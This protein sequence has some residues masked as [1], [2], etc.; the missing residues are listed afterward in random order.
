MDRMPRSICEQRP[1]EIVA[2]CRKLYQR[3]SFQE[4]TLGEISKETSISRPSI[5][6]YFH[7]KEEIFLA[8]LQE[9]Y[10]LWTA[11]LTQSFAKHPALTAQEYA[12][13]VGQSLEKRITLLKIQCM[14]LYEIEEHSRL[15]CLVEFKKSYQ[16]TLSTVEKSL[17]KFFPAMSPKDR[18]IFLYLFFPFL[19]GLYP[20]VY[21]TTQQQ[22]AMERAHIQLSPQKVSDLAALCLLKLLPN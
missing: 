10:E 8:L 7:S 19:Y 20:Y 9:E 13:L 2:A 3:L 5:Y 12:A 15:E 17:E 4:I 21:P 14:N 22:E 16:H 18:E 1:Q 11:D 6:N